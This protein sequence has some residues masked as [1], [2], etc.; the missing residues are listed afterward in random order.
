MLTHFLTSSTIHGLNYL[1]NV[2]S[3]SL[4]AKLFW[5]LC[6]LTSFTMAGL[7]IYGNVVN[8]NNSPTSIMKSSPVL[9][10]ESH[11]DP[12]MITVCQ[13]NPDQISLVTNFFN[14]PYYKRDAEFEAQ[15]N[16]YVM[17]L[18]PKMIQK[19]ML[20]VYGRMDDT[21]KQT[22]LDSFEQGCTNMSSR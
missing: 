21:Q 17:Y 20:V 12:P 16:D 15:I 2:D 13:G 10:K 3:R 19:E 6:V 11:L 8:W 4:F 18:V 9:L 5:L 7:F 14:S 1:A 22:V